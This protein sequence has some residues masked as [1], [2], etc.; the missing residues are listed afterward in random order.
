MI[1]GVV[2]SQITAAPAPVTATPSIES[3]YCIDDGMGNRYVYADIKNNDASSVTIYS[4]GISKGT[5]TA[6]QTKAFIV[7]NIPGAPYDYDL[8]I[9]AQASGESLSL[10]ATQ[11]G[12]VSFCISM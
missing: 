7:A 5:W 6:G 11:S 4:S 8:S 10:P 3:V 9:T 1:A 2:A 12:T